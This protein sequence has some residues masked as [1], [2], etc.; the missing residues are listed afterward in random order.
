MMI[1]PVKIADAQGIR[2]IYNYYIV[3]TAISFEE[4]P[5]SASEMESRIRTITAKYPW[6]VRE[7]EGEILAYTY[8]NTWRERAAYRYSAELSM[9][10]QKGRE[11][12]GMGSALMARLLEAARQ[13]E[14]RV[15][16]S[17]ITIPNERSIALHEKFGFRNAALFKGIGFKLGQWL[18][19]GYWELELKRTGPETGNPVEGTLAVRG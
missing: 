8:I 1:R 14:I 9:Y 15:L 6:F 17:G 3:N 4:E 13:T 10:V 12:Q 16:V 5:V 2:E 7:E 19:V 18:D 11:G